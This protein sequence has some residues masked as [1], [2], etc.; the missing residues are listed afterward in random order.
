M[1]GDPLWLYNLKAE[2]ASQAVAVASEA[3]AATEPPAPTSNQ[4]AATLDPS[5]AKHKQPGKPPLGILPLP[6][7]EAAARAMAYGDR[8]YAPGNWR[9]LGSPEERAEWANAALRH[10]YAHL[11]GERLDESGVSH[12]GHAA[13]SLLI[14]EWHEAQPR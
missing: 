12:L 13:A 10:I 4:T 14:L 1:T 2:S 3:R 11:S 6:G 5:E 7:L 8:K 9:L